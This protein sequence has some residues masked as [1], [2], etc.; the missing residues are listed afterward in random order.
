MEIKINRDDLLKSVSRVQSIIERKSNMPVLS[1][2]LFTA[3]SSEVQISATDLELGFR[4][5]VQANVISEGSITISGRKIFEIIR[6]SRSETFHIQ[7]KENN[8]VLISDGV[9]K[10]E[11]ACIHADEFPSFMEPE[12]VSMIEIEGEI[13]SDMINKT[14]YAVTAEEA[15]FKLS[16]I[17]TEKISS[18]DGNFLR[19][20]AT[21]GHRLSLVDK[22]VPN[23]GDLDMNAGILVAR[24]GMSEINKMASE[25]GTVQIGFE[26]KNCIVRKNNAFLMIRLLETRF[27]DYNMVIPKNEEYSIKLERNALLEAM[28]KMLILSNDRYRAVKITLENNI[29]DLV[30]T[31]PEIGEGQEQIG[32]EFTGEPITAGFNPKFFVDALQAME[33]D[34][35]NL[36]FTDGSKPCTIRG[37][38]DKG[39]I[40]LI[41]PM[42]V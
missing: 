7:E 20:V 24:K 34:A 32:I 28:K 35:I 17:L 37:E 26:E 27:P 13:L 9:A 19:M 42:R 38:A 22:P 1:T 40:G 36:G 8:R 18:S 11:L 41:M 33:S 6:E 30:S 15:G 12:G 4:Q 14:I 16:G 10:F 3:Q 39:F 21:D 23:V 5:I 25:G 31:N 29:L 2:I